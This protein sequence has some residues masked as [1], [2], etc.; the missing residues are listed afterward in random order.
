M[1]QHSYKFS[2][3]KALILSIFKIQLYPEYGIESLRNLC[4]PVQWDVLIFLGHLDLLSNLT[5]MIL[6]HCDQ[7][8]N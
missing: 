5:G 4:S 6:E 8:T 7:S 1:Y 3:L 2:Q